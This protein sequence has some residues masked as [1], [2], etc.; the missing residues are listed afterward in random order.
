MPHPMSPDL[1]ARLLR[2][3][4]ELDGHARIARYLGLDLERP[5]RALADGYPE[6]A[7]VLVGRVIERLLKRLWVHHGVP[8]TPAGKTLKDLISGCRPYIRSHRVLEA[9]YDIQ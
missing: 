1:D 9:L 3:K 5:V 6:N 2:L 7:V 8:G 4:T